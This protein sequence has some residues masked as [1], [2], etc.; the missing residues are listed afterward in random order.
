MQPQSLQKNLLSCHQ[1]GFFFFSFLRSKIRDINSGNENLTS[2]DN[3]VKRV[4]GGN[5]ALIYSCVHECLP[6]M[7]STPTHMAAVSCGRE[8]V[9][10]SQSISND[11]ACL[12]VS[13]NRMVRGLAAGT[14]SGS[15]IL[16]LW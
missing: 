10:H 14:V 4:V 2:L 1:V 3:W 9:W 6:A 8:S 7:L 11:G 16:S 5:G 13:S 15:F 12:L